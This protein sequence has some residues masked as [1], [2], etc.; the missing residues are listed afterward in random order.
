MNEIDLMYASYS[1]TNWRRM[2]TAPQHYYDTEY[3]RLASENVGDTEWEEL[4][5]YK[6]II[7][8]IDFYILSQ[9]FKKHM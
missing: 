1:S 7:N 3:T 9:N 4:M 8:D 2:R 6:E 5:R